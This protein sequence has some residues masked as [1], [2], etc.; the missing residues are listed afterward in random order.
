MRIDIHAILDR[1][2][3]PWLPC[4]AYAG[5]GADGRP[6]EGGS[7]VWPDAL[8][9]A[10]AV[11]LRRPWKRRARNLAVYWKHL[12]TAPPHN[13][14]LTWPA[15]QAQDTLGRDPAADEIEQR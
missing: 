8:A 5:V 9:L 11:P 1:F 15:S 6:V 12:L 14:P 4:L 2:G 3:C 10:S 13:V 7:A